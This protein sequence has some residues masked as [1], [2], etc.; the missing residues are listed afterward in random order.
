MKKQCHPHHPTSP[1]MACLNLT[2]FYFSTKRPQI[3]ASSH[4]LT[5]AC[6]VIFCCFFFFFYTSCFLLSPHPSSGVSRASENVSWVDLLQ[7]LQLSGTLRSE[8][9]QT[10]VDDSV[11]T[12]SRGFAGIVHQQ[13]TAALKRGLIQLARFHSSVCFLWRVQAVSLV[14]HRHRFSSVDAA[15]PTELVLQQSFVSVLYFSLPHSS[16]S[17]LT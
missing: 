8:A 7:H 9:V 1:K 11:W 15:K 4:R 10:L 3:L 2:M 14:I 12:A 6:P 16:R 5:T 13:W 17:A